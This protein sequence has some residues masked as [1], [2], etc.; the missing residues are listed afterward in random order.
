MIER[1]RLWRAERRLARLNHHL[2]SDLAR[3]RQM[4]ADLRQLL[5]DRE[6][7]S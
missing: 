1:W 5:K 2:K 6:G 7:P 4:N 3:V